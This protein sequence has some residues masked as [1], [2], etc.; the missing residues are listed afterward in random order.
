MSAPH[1]GVNLPLDEE[2]VS[3]HGLTAAFEIGVSR[4]EHESERRGEALNWHTLTFSVVPN[5]GTT[6]D[7]APYVGA[8]R[9]EK[10]VA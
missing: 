5:I 8:L 2:A 7:E 10:L 4:L 9:I 1:A 3:P 6:R